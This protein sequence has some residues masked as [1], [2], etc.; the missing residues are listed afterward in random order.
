MNRSTEI[1]LLLSL[2]IEVIGLD[3]L[4]DVFQYIFAVTRHSVDVD[5][6]PLAFRSLDFT[7]RSDFKLPS[8]EM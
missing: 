8:D 3:A 7:L 6:F 4:K 2:N 1:L 5:E